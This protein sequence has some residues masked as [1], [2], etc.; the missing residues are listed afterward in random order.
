MREI[1]KMSDSILPYI[2]FKEEV[3]SD[4][5][6]GKLPMLDFTVWKVE[7][8]DDRR[9]AGKKIESSTKGSRQMKKTEIVCFFTKQGGGGTLKPNYFCFFHRTFLL[10]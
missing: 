3:A 8:K 1:R 6:G 7:E 2:K 9:K 10:L 5:V 4:C